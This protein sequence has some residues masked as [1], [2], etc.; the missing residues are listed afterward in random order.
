MSRSSPKYRL[1]ERFQNVF[2]GT[3]YK[4]RDSS[5][6]DSIAIEFYED[7]HNL[8]K[9]SKLVSRIENHERVINVQNVRQGVKARRGDGTFGELIP[10]ED[11]LALSGFKVA[12]GR[13]ATVEIGVEV[14]ILAKA[15]IKQI[16]RVMTDLGNQVQHFKRKAGTPIC[17]AVVGINWS[18]SYTSYEG[19]RAWPTDGKK[20]VHPIQEAAQAESRLR[21]EIADK[22]DEFLVLRFRA[23]NGA[24]FPFEWIDYRETFRDYGAIL[25]RIS[26]EYEQRF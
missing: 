7:L 22:F 3:R 16:D 10:G 1:L 17:V 11:A 18:P 4:H 12:R 25:T 5:I 13:I 14:K 6:G 2:E 9:S 21:E 8:H 24:P 15:M 23:T 19:D 26:R 20:Y